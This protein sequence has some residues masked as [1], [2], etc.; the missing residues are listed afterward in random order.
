LGGEPETARRGQ[1][2][3]VQGVDNFAFYPQVKLLKVCEKRN[4]W[5]E[6]LLVV[7]ST[8]KAPR[9]ITDLNRSAAP[10]PPLPIRST[11]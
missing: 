5:I 2:S 11:G 9:S 7:L 8:E 1:L 10:D 6:S 3:T 4:A